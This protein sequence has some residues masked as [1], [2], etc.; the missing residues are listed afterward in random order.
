MKRLSVLT[1]LLIY[2]M[3]VSA[4]SVGTHSRLSLAALQRSVLEVNADYLIDLGLEGAVTGSLGADY[5]DMAF[6]QAGDVNDIDPRSAEIFPKE[7]GPMPKIPNPESLEAWLMRGAIR[8]DDVPCP[9][10]PCDDPV[11]TIRVIHHFYDPINNEALTS[12]LVIGE[13][14]SRGCSKL[15]VSHD[16]R[17]T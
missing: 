6:D 9:F 2:V 4:Y 16:H 8:E 12:P 10:S 14:K 5:F 11:N 13:R 3:D 17:L 7:N 1:L 15:C